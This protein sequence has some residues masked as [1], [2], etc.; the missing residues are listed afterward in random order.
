MKFLILSMLAKESAHG[1]ELKAQLDQ[2][3]GRLWPSINMGQVYVTLKRLERDGHVRSE[4]VEQ[5]DRP[6]KKVFELTAAGREALDEWLHTVDGDYR[7]RDGFFLRLVAAIATPGGPDVPTLIDQQ[8]RQLL[9]RLRQ[10]QQ[11]GEQEI[12]STERLAVESTLLHLQAELRW[13]EVCEVQLA[14]ERVKE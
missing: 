1:Y 12:I 8:R 4:M 6:D 11:L 7:I 5:T 2:A 9:R 13:L 3:L 10:V 14:N